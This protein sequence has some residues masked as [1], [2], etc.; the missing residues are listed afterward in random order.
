MLRTKIKDIIEGYLENTC[1]EPL[2]DMI[3]D[4]ISQELET[5]ESNCLDST[6]S[7]ELTAV[8]QDF[9]DYQDKGVQLILCELKK[10]LN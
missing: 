9:M 10:S 7:E 1:G 5:A 8:G 2:T 4:A 3:C 6:P